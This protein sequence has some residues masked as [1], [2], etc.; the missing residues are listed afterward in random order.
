M[1]IRDNKG[2]ITIFVLVG[3]LF[4]TGFL[5]I[6]FGSNINKSKIAKEQLNILSS[7]YSRGDGDASAY[8]RAYTTIRRKNAQILTESSNNSSSLELTKTFTDKVSNYKIY[9]NSVQ[10]GTPSPTNPVE[11][12]S[13][14]EKTRNLFDKDNINLTL[15]KVNLRTS[16]ISP[17]STLVLQPNTYKLTIF[18]SNAIN[19]KYKFMYSILITQGGKNQEIYLESSSVSTNGVFTVDQETTIRGIYVFLSSSD[20]NTAQITIDKIQLEEGNVATEYEP[21]GKYKIPVKVSGKNLFD[22]N[23]SVNAPSGTFNNVTVP[24]LLTLYLKPNTAY[25]LSSNQ[26]GDTTAEPSDIYRSLYFNGVSNSN[27]V[28]NGHSVTATTDDTGK[29]QI[30]LFSQRTNAEN[31]VN[32]TAKIQLEEGSTATDYEPYVEPVTTNIY[33][34]EPLRKVGGHAD[35]IDFSTG[36]VERVVNKEVFDGT[37]TWQK[38][39]SVENR[40]L[41]YSIKPYTTS[42]TT[43]KILCDRLISNGKREVGTIDLSYTLGNP[44]GRQLIFG[45]EFETLDEFK[46]YVVDEYNSGT[47]MYILYALYEE[48]DPETIDL[49]ELKTFEDYTKVE[50]LTEVAPSKIEATYY[51]Y[52]ME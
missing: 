15:H 49:P 24:N 3:L 10:N 2:S 4:M 32:K 39:S 26:N 31:I 6:S 33:L 35:Y 12:Q 46:Q 37:E 27:A 47:P 11:I 7:I 1:K 18:T 50:V 29:L 14:G 21:Y 48:D 36:T 44:S 5:I 30:I 22:I 23:A 40:Y 17:N 45:M 51:G 28:F 43:P 52:T 9:G 42:I 20:N 13:V 8:E 25:T 19:I 16:T 34:D 41:I 38:S